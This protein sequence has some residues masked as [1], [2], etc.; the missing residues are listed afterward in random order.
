MYK[1]TQLNSDTNPRNDIG[2]V[3]KANSLQSE[4]LPERNNEALL[5]K[6]KSTLKEIK[7]AM[8]F[9]GV[10]LIASNQI[11]MPSSITAYS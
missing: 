5:K 7:N 1:I 4:Q 2:V 6:T 9:L 8:K 10:F 3:G 11:K